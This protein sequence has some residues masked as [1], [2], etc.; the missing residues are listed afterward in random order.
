MIGR[1]WRRLFRRND[2]A[3]TVSASDWEQA[4]M[5][6]PGLD[7]ISAAQSERLRAR[8]TELLARK[9]IAGVPGFELEPQMRTR[10]ALL[11][12]LPII[13]LGLD[14]YRNFYTFLVYPDDF[15]VDREVVD[16]AGVVHRVREPLAGETALQGAVI[17]SWTAVAESGLGEGFNVVVHELAHKLDMLGSGGS[18]VPRL[19]SSSWSQ[20]WERDFD[21]LRQS[22]ADD[23]DPPLDPYAATDP[24]ECFAV[25]SEYFFD[26]PAHLR[27]HA[28][29][30]Y[31]H[32]ARFYRIDPAATAP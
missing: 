11:A 7:W 20:A 30:V 15:L 22:L 16:E 8:A 13:E 3:A 27:E 26:A 28:P 18:G 29:Q 31:S 10:I 9:P 25:C 2:A 21:A 5:Q 14:W 32:L 19:N 24:L 6:L 12:A 1:G 17:I 4:L 23:P